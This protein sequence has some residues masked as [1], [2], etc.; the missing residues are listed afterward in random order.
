MLHTC[1]IREVL[2]LPKALNYPIEALW[3]IVQI[4]PGCEFVA[5]LSLR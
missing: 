3:K 1:S 4:T 5:V 2:F